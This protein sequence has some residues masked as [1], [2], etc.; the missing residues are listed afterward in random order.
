MKSFP[1]EALCDLETWDIVREKLDERNIH[2]DE[3]RRWAKYGLDYSRFGIT[4]TEMFAMKSP[5]CCRRSHGPRTGN[6]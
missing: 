4:H 2:D 3:T 6:T 1:T 5:S